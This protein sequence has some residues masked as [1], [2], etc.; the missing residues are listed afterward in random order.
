MTLVTVLR[1]PHLKGWP[2]NEQGGQT[3][4][5]LLSQALV[6]AYST[7][8]HFAQYQSPIRRRLTKGAAER[9]GSVTLDVISFDVDC[10][11]THG[12]PTPAPES[13]REQER[14]KL[15]A[16]WAVH[17]G[18]FAY[19][20]RGG[21]RFLYRQPLPT[22][23]TNAADALSWSQD[24]TICRMYLH[25]CFGFEIDKSCADWQ[26]LFRLPRAT[27]DGKDR[28]EDWPMYG[29]PESIAT[30]VIE[31]SELDLSNARACKAFK[32]RKVLDL[33]PCRSDGHGL[34]YHALSA[35]R[36]ILGPHEG[37]YLIRCPR[38]SA[39][40]CGSTGDTSTVLYLPANGK[41][42]GFIYC[43]HS[44]CVELSVRDWLRCFS[45]SELDA[46]RERAGIRR[47]A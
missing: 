20:T 45:D 12:T 22:L 31:P 28:P 37:G 25:R 36:D 26:R 4:L 14:D 27:R 35:R 10:P 7:D 47:T 42:L 6:Q 43:K 18:M 24:Y 13:W 40:S 41:E 3:D 32:K 11:E 19:E 34:L 1:S 21:Y 46:A 38:E 8:A 29:N 30:L 2:K 15:R 23:I 5:V 39:H 44:H 9:L 33:K 16:L 17:P